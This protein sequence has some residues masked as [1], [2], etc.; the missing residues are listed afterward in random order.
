MEPTTAASSRPLPTDV[1]DTRGAIASA[2]ALK[3]GCHAPAPRQRTGRLMR[4]LAVLTTGFAI[5]AAVAAPAS[6]GSPRPAA[7][8]FASAQTAGVT[9]PRDGGGG[10]ATPA[11][12]DGARAVQAQASVPL[13]TDFAAHARR[14]ASLDTPLIVL[15]SLRDCVYCGPI[16]QRELAPLVRGGKYEVREIGM[17]ST[18]P[19]REFDGSTTT[20]VAWARAHGVKVSPTVLF[21]DTSGHPVADPLIGAGLP[22]FYGAYLDNAIAQGRTQL[23]AGRAAATR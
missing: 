14:A 22:D 10:S 2:L 5:G 13:A 16:R 1:C 19:V 4:G 3:P 11:Q 20:G 18:A 17:D 21:L 9:S 7:G 23:R 8:N 12:N 6:D 15:V